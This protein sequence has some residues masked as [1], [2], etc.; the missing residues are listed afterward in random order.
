MKFKSISTQEISQTNVAKEVDTL[1]QWHQRFYHQNIKY[2]QNYLSNMQ[3]P[4]SEPKKEFCCETCIYRKPHRESFIMS[5]TKTAEPGEIVHTNECGLMEQDSIG[6][7][8]YFVL[9]KGDYTNYWHVYFLTRKSEV[10]EKL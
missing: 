2:I 10:K 7:K 5:K 6:R 9:F 1:K 3:I 8:Q 4:F